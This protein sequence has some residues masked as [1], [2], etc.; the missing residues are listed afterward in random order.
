M[1]ATS[2]ALSNKR[3]AGPTKGLP[4]KSSS[5]PGCSP[6]NRTFA[7]REPSP[8]TVCVP[9]FQ[10]S[11]AWQPAAAFLTAV[12]VGRGGIKSQA[13]LSEDLN[14]GIYRSYRPYRSYKTNVAIT[15]RDSNDN[16][17]SRTLKS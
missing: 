10:R 17:E 1:P 5:L 4:V 12:S 2:S 15:L 13:L 8:K 14:F 6:S 9:F 3:P 7:R 11:Q 16:H